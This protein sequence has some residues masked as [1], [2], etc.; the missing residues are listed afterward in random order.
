MSETSGKENKELENLKTLASTAKE[1][2]NWKEAI[3]YYNKI[4][5]LDTEN[6][7]AWFGKG[8]CIINTS[9]IGDIKMQESLS[10][11]KNAIKF[12][13]DENVKKNSSYFD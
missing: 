1:G 5:E 10:Y 8:L 6:Y 12:S 4:L 2:G 13:N 9:T 7:D 11:Y 3:D